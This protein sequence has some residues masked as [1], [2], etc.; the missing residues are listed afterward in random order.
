[1]ARPAVVI[2]T[3]LERLSQ[4]TL[5]ELHTAWRRWHRRPPPSRLSRDLLM[6]GI[7]YKLQETAHGG[8]SKRLL[9]RLA[10]IEGERTRSGS[11]RFP[12]PIALKPGTRLVREWHGITHTVLI[13]R[14]GVEW[15][16]QRWRSLSVVAREITGAHWSGPRFFGLTSGRVGD[17]QSR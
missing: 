17:G 12:P 1:M 7:A 16:G 11:P 5:L 10:Q 9:R 2:T 4:L 14:D 13:H 8:L 3:Q 15:R 6:R